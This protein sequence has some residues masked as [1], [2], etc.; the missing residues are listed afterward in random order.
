MKYTKG[1]EET[2]PRALDQSYKVCEIKNFSSIVENSTPLKE[3]FLSPNDPHRA[4]R[5]KQNIVI[6]YQWAQA[7]IASTPIIMGWKEKSW[8]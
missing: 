8:V 4:K 2:L 3:L 6:M 5:E 1:W 7:K